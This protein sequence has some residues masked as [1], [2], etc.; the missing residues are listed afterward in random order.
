MFR[1]N[2]PWFFH[3]QFLDEILSK[4]RA[5]LEALL[6]KSVVHSNNVLVGLL[7]GVPEEGGEAG[8]H[9]VRDH[10]DAPEVGVQGQRLVVD[11]LGTHELRRAKHLADLQAKYFSTHTNIL[12]CFGGNNFM[13]LYVLLKRFVV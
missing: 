11:N 5:V 6:V 7:L 8:E 10:A 1:C 13:K 3:Q 4:I 9:D 2:K 12:R